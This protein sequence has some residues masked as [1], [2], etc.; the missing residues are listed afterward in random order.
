MLAQMRVKITALF[1]RLQR[2]QSPR[3]DRHDQNDADQL[4]TDE[5]A[6]RARRI[7]LG[8][9]GAAP[10]GLSAIHPRDI[11]IKKKMR[12]VPLLLDLNI[13]GEAP[14]ETGAAPPY[15]RR[16]KRARS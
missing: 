7:R 9:G 6:R 13:S 8:G 4:G 1:A 12:S 5:P 14:K 10:S 16:K 11:F 15:F 2:Q 3:R